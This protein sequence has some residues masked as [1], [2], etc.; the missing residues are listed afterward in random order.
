VQNEPAIYKGTHFSVNDDVSDVR[1]PE[2]TVPSSEAAVR[3]LPLPD[4]V[5]YREYSV[6]APAPADAYVD[7]GLCRLLYDSQINLESTGFANHLRTIQRIVTR[8]GAE[9]AAHFVVEFDPTHQRI[10]VHFIRVLRGEAHVDHAKADALQLLRRETRLERLALDGRLTA[11]LR[12]PDLR[13][14]DVLDVS[15]TIHSNHPIL[16]GKYAGWLAF[17]AFTP[18]LEVRHRLLRPPEREVFAKPFNQPPDDAV[19]TSHGKYES[20]WSLAAQERRE[21]EELTPP[22]Q[23]QVP[24]IQLTEFRS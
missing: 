23:I 17:N 5:E 22:W 24:A 15:I 13:I 16:G 2:H 21:T 6:R 3:F 1:R 9:K 10:D 19:L 20:V 8:A 4:W 12:I 18:W 11:T 14:D 7:N